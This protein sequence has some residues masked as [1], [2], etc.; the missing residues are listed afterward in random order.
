MIDLVQGPTIGLSNITLV[1]FRGYED[2]VSNMSVG[3]GSSNRIK[4]L[5]ISVYSELPAASLANFG[6]D[7]GFY[8]VKARGISWG[9]LCLSMGA[10]YASR[11]VC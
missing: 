11:F 5:Q 2:L 3:P 8:A 1:S 4:N 10:F 7:W 9:T 6:V